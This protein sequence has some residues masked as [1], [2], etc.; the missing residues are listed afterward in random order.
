M[1][2][3]GIRILGIAPLVALVASFTAMPATADE[4]TSPDDSSI[5]GWSPPEEPIQLEPIESLDEPRSGRQ[6]GLN[7][8]RLYVVNAKTLSANSYVNKSQ[9]LGSCKMLSPGTCT[10]SVT[11]SSTRTISLSLGATR[12]TVA[13][14]LGISSATTVSNGTACGSTLLKAGQT[15][16]AYPMGGRYSYQI[17]KRWH[18]GSIVYSTERSGTLYAFNPASNRIACGL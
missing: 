6:A 10:V 16:K 8:T 14:N 2:H 15:W 3:F 13:A 5:A 11:A 17:E 7:Y 9:I 12:G 1:K 4:A 18:S